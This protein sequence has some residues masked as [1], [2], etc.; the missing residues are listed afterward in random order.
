MALVQALGCM[1]LGLVLIMIDLGHPERFL[2]V[3]LSWNPSSVLAW[4]CLFYTAYI[5][6]ILLELYFAL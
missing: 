2:N 6:I 4:E 1:L 5:V 3:F